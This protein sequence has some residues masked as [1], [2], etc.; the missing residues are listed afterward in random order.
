MIHLL[1]RTKL[2]GSYT[3]RKLKY[4]YWADL[5]AVKYGVDPWK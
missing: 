3:K 2:T 1:Q 4:S 5:S